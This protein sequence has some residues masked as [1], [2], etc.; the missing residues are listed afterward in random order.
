MAASSVILG[1]SLDVTSRL[2]GIALLTM[3]AAVVTAPA[4]GQQAQSQSDGRVIVIGEGS[5]SVTPDHAQIESGVT[6]RAK[7][8]KEAVDVNSKLM[9]AITSALLGSGIAQNDV[10][11]SRFSVQPVYAPQ[12][13]RT[14]PKLSGYSVSNH[15]TV[16]IRQ[17]DKV[18]EILDRLVAAGSTDLGNIEFLASDPSKA[19][20][21]AREAAIDDARH[22]AQVYTQAFGLQLGRVVWITEEPGFASPISM[23]AQGASAA[24]AAPIPIAAG[25]ETL[26]V[27]I[28]VGFEIAR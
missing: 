8:V 17:I 14:E 9:A 28:T 12:E 5:V 20:D 13:P 19:L 22:K 7:T 16:K 18:G 1:F 26:R 24:R 25:E 27:R 2:S 15:V 3:A 10:Q 4:Q 11:T 21:Q 23:R 6:T